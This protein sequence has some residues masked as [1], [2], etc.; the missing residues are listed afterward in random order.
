MYGCRP[1]PFV[2]IE[3]TE[4]IELAE[5]ELMEV[6]CTTVKHTLQIAKEKKKKTLSVLYRSRTRL[7]DLY[8]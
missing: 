7:P 6:S 4:N 5:V 2:W 8:T 3:F 1:G